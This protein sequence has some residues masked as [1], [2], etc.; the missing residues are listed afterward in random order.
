MLTSAKRLRIISPNP[1]TA[2]RPDPI[3]RAISRGNKDV[4]ARKWHSL[5]ESH[6]NINSGALD[7]R[8]SRRT[9]DDMGVDLGGG[10]AFVGPARPTAA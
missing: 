7:E 9:L 8:H 3:V 1:S 4:M 5:R 10:G 6:A 2:S